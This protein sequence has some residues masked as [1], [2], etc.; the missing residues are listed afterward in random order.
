VFQLGLDFN[1][2]MCTLKALFEISF[3]VFYPVIP[4]FA[5]LANKGISSHGEV[6][7]WLKSTVC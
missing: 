5:A 7:E 2:L 6:D 1:A 4:I 3:W